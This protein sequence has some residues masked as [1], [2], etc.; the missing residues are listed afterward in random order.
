V[1]LDFDTLAAR[2]QAGDATAQRT[3]GDLYNTGKMGRIDLTQ[4]FNHYAAA[5]QQGD[6]VAQ[7]RLANM[8]AKGREYRPTR[9]KPPNGLTRQLSAVIPRPNMK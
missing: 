2:A 4:A 8:Y 5:A 1:P 3:L 6:S 9:P 7:F